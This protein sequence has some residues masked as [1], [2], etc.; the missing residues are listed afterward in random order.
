MD[1]HFIIEVPDGITGQPAPQPS[2]V[3]VN[4]E[5]G[6]ALGLLGNYDVIDYESSADKSARQRA[7]HGSMNGHRLKTLSLFSRTKVYA[8]PHTLANL[9][10]SLAHPLHPQGRRCKQRRRIQW[11]TWVSGRSHGSMDRVAAQMR[12]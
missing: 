12:N 11:R 4:S 8:Q 5:R 1:G 2:S 9:P 10:N 3:S 6:P 7:E